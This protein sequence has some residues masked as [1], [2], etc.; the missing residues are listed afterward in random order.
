MKKLFFVLFLSLTLQLNAFAKTGISFIYINGSNIKDAKIKK[1]YINGI[2]K[3]HPHMKNAFEQEGFTQKRILKNGKYFIEESPLI[4]SWGDSNHKNS[5]CANNSKTPKGPI[6]WFSGKIRSTATNLLHDIIW[7]QNYH[8]MNLV[9]DKLHKTVMAEI[10]K[11]NKII[12]YGYSSGSFITYDY[13][14]ARIPYINIAELFNYAN[15]SKQQRDFVSQHPMKNT[16]MH[17]LVQN[18]AT[19]S[20]E[21]HII[22][23]NDLNSFEKNYM[24]LNEA[25]DKVCVPCNAI[26]GVVNIASPLV[27]FNSDISDPGFQITYYNRLLYKYIFE[28]DMFWLTVNYREDPLSFPS[29]RN[30]TIEEIENRINLAIEPNAGFIYDQSDTKGGFFAM[31]HLHYLKRTKALANAIAKA[32]ENGYRYQYSKC[33]EQKNIIKYPQKIDVKP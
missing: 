8:N 4:F 27:L 9:L 26:V 23:N 14:L 31:T 13:L 28:N 22:I 1:W 17:A 12:F 20:A 25:T 32:Y 11:G 24:N 30:L 18:F 3:F 2:K 21:G 15:V 7:V 19:L 16:C 33:F 29:G 6:V 10:Q 5:S